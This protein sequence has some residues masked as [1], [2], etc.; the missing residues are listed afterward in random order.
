MTSKTFW[1][2]AFMSVVALIAA[3]ACILLNLVWR[4]LL[5]LVL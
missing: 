4:K 5:G 2:G 3:I 1:A